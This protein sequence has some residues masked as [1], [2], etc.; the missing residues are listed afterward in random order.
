LI[1][2]GRSGVRQFAVYASLHFGSLMSVKL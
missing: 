2:H 1:G